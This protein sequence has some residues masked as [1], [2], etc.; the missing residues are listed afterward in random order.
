MDALDKKVLKIAAQICRLNG[1]RAS[2]RA[3]QDWR[4]DTKILDSLTPE[5]KDS[6]S[7]QYEEFNSNGEDFE[8]GYF[9][10]DEMTVS[11]IVARALDLLIKDAT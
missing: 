6:L 10:Y 7:L 9:P 11:Y 3:C 4:E 1:T 8:S 5:E 2:D